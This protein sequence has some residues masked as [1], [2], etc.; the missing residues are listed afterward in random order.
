MEKHGQ[1]AILQQRPKDN[2]ICSTFNLIL[3]LICLFL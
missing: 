1:F 2:E 3:E